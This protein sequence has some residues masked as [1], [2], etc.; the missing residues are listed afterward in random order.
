[1]NRDLESLSE[2]EPTEFELRLLDAARGER[3]SAELSARMAQGLGLTLPAGASVLG[4]AKS[5]LAW[6]GGLGALAAVGGALLVW[7]LWDKNPAQTA[8][9]SAP[10]VSE[11]KLSEQSAPS[12]VNVS[13]PQSQAVAEV[14]AA[15]AAPAPAPPSARP[16][17]ATGGD[18][19]EEIR[20]IDAAR[21][22]VASRSYDQALSILRRYSSTYPSGTFGQE[23]SVLRFEALDRSG[24]HGRAQVLARDFLSR[25]ANSPLAE[26]AERVANR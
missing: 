18:L 5:G 21:S 9:P 10:V 7:A 26:R 17:A 6:W 14:E 3:P 11:A 1:M 23:A 12:P 16:A 20:L 19:R 22:A 13:P 8:A 15:K 4:A 24:Q 2:P 25:H